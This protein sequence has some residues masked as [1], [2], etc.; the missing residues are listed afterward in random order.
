MNMRLKN[1]LVFLLITVAYL[2]ALNAAEPISSSKARAAML[3]LLSTIETVQD[4]FL[5]SANQVTSADDIAEGQ[6]AIA[7]ILETALYFW[8]EADPEHPEFKPYVSSTRKLLG[9][10]P[11]SIYYFAPIRDDR[12]YK[13]SG[14]IGAA[15]FTSFTV[16]GGSFDGH[17]ARSSIA[18]LSDDD[19][20]IAADG[21]YEIIVS[22]KKPNWGKG[23]KGNWLPIKE[24]AGQIS[25]R[26]YHEAKLSVAANPKYQMDINIAPL[27]PQP[28]ENYGGDQQ[29]A[30]HLTYVANFVGEHAAMSLTTPTEAAIGHLGWYSLVPNEFGK[31]GQWVSAS[32]DMAYGNTHA[33]YNAANYDLAEDEALVIETRLPASRF[34]NVVL[35]NRFMQTYDYGKRQVSLNRKQMQFE[36][37]GSVR[38]VIAHKDPG[39]PNW[40]DTEGRPKGNIYWRFVYPSEEPEAPVTRVVKLADL[41]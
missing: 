41:K 34:I 11:D 10:N 26:H 32:G 24:G 18:A 1:L 3:N 2:P 8:L 20:E 14:N 22:R 29:V 38:I 37:D 21:S 39:V 35:W 6:R 23:K 7:H 13:I 31:A 25:T 19:M 28:L 16:E 5:N 36:E 40:L 30:D 33:Y 15:T 27:D 9:D 12:S 4:K 17:A